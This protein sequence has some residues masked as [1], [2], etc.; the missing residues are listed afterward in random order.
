[1]SIACEP[2]RLM[3]SDYHI[4]SVDEGLLAKMV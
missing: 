1:V 4:L 3:N 2:E